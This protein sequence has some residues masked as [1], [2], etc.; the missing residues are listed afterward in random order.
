MER[1]EIEGYPEYDITEDGLV[2]SRHKDRWLKPGIRMPYGY[3]CYYL[4]NNKVG[5]WYYAHR[6][7]MAMFWGECPAGMVVRHKDGNRQNNCKGNLEYVTH[8]DIIL[9]SF[10]AEGEGF[11]NGKTK[12]PHSLATKLKMSDA[13]KKSVCAINKGLGEFK[14][15]ES[16]SEL[17]DY[18]GRDGMYRKKFNRI[19]RGD[20]LFGEWKFIWKTV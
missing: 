9:A 6:L 13:K 10:R 16:V 4:T 3:V 14:T 15:F 8:R 19:M 11:W 2:Y 12:A 18:F 1:K 7:V 17:I 20:C 5:K